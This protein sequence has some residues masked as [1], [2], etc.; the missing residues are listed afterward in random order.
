MCPFMCCGTAEQGKI[1]KCFHELRR[2]TLPQFRFGKLYVTIIY[3]FT[4]KSER[5]AFSDR[6]ILLGFYC[7]Y[8]VDS[9]D[10]G[11]LMF[12]IFLC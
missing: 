10:S 5:L 12:F 9:L 2:T 8:D 6:G 11:T 4:V 3:V 1:G 7:Q